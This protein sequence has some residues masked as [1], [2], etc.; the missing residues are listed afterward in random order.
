MGQVYLARDTRLGREVAIKVLP[1][2]VAGNPE[3][4]ARFER[5]ARTVASLNHPNI[6]TLHDIADVDGVRFLVMERV[7]GRTLAA[8]LDRAGELP[9]IRI[10]ELMVPVADALASAHER[11]IVHRD[12]EPANIMVNDD[13][14]VKVLDFG[15]A[16]ERV[17]P[18][19]ADGTT[20]AKEALTVEGSILG[21]VS[22]MAPEQVR[23]ERVD[24]RADLFACGVILYEMASGV[25]PFRG[26]S[27]I[28]IA[29][30]I[31]SADPRPLDT[32]IRK[33]RSSLAEGPYAGGQAS[34]TDRAW[35]A[36]GDDG[37]W[38]GT[39]AARAP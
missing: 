18:F 21:T 35:W 6:V 26:A 8:F 32:M 30:A 16:T 12:L 22:Y 5:E 29:S 20:V 3:R 7:S 34:A 4:L 2:D 37:S 17:A 25:R 39:R 10:L 15:L 24:T 27:A 28:D 9:L 33:L 1:A 31:L 23:G 36:R 13:G 11:G 14:R 19:G 38:G